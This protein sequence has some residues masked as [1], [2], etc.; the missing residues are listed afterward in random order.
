MLQEIFFFQTHQYAVFEHGDAGV[1]G[2]IGD[3]GFF[4]KAIAFGENGE[5][6]F[7]CIGRRT[8][9][10]RAFSFLHDVVVVISGALLDDDLAFFHRHFFQGH[11]QRLDIFSRQVE[12]GAR[13]QETHHPVAAV[14]TAEFIHLVGAGGVIIQQNFKKIRVDGEYGRIG[15]RAAGLAA[16][17]LIGQRLFSFTGFGADN[18]AA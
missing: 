10:D 14:I 13:L 7:G 1:A 12:K 4:A 16:G 9:A 11:E 3:Q 15:F 8:A 2:A 17:N 5:L 6:H 18:F